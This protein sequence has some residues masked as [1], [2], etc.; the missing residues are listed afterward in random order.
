MTFLKKQQEIPELSYYKD[1]V[2]TGCQPAKERY[3]GVTKVLSATKDTTG[4]DAWVQRVGKEEADRVISESK[5]I[6]VSLDTIFNDSL[7]DNRNNFEETS[8]H[9]TPGFKL[10]RQLKPYIARIEPIQVQM[11][12]WSDNLKM[13]GYLDCFGFYDNDLS[14]IDC[15]NAKREKTE[16]HLLDYY[17]QTTAYSLMLYDMYGIKIKK[18]V[19][20]I[21]R[22]D[23]AFP[24]I[25]VKPM[26]DFIPEVLKRVKNYYSEK[27]NELQ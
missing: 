21:A 3:P 13:M 10:Y 23:Q 16:E 2:A 9:G 20:L 14:V 1:L 22:R 12:V 15:K 11:K 6:G 8:Y 18:I 24:Q 5:A 7:S 17:L 4:L 26:K 27:I 25:V 19:L